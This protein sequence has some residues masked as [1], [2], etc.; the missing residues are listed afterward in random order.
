MLY[1]CNTCKQLFGRVE[2][3]PLLCAAC[4]SLDVAPIAEEV[5]GY[6]YVA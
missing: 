5:S 6:G 2:D 4:G 3:Y 1:L